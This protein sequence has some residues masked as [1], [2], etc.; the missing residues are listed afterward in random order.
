MIKLF[1]DD[2]RNPPTDDYVVVR[3]YAEAVGY[4]RINGCPDYISFDHDLGD[5]VPTGYD[6]A[7]WMVERDLNDK[8]KFIPANFHFDVHSANPVGAENIRSLLNRYLMV[9]NDGT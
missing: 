8:G 5:N 4:M 3:S 9:K 6:I 7:K 1:I 2:I